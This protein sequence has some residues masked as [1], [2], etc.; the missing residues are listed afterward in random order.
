[1]RYSPDGNYWASAGFDGKVFIY[2]A[3]DS[4]LLHELKDGDKNAHGGGVYGIAWSPDSKQLLSA[5]GDKTC[6]IWN[7]VDNKLVCEFIMGTSVDDQQLGC[8]WSGDYLVSVSLSG[9]INYMDPK[10]PGK[11]SMVIEGHNKPVTTMTISKDGKT[12][13]TGG[14]DGRVLKWNSENGEARRV[15]GPGH[16]SQV[17]CI[18]FKDSDNL[19]TLG[20]DDTFRIIESSTFLGGS[21]LK[22]GGQPK[23]GAS[24]KDLQIVVTVNGSVIFIQNGAKVK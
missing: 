24:V 6:R 23:C 8:L 16:E 22:L 11:P 3:K 14:S 1:M 9:H 5:S 10:N 13:F 15:Q 19:F 20:I 7:A 18:D 12:I 4:T 17:N 2:E 21:D